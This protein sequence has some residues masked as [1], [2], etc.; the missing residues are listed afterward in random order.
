MVTETL[1]DMAEWLDMPDLDVKADE[2]QILFAPALSRIG[3][4]PGK[5]IYCEAWRLFLQWRKA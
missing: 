2:L 3:L 5:I 1:F 4:H